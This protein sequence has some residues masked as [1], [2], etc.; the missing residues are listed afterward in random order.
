M[1]ISCEDSSHYNEKQFSNLQLVQVDE[2]VVFKVKRVLTPVTVWKV[3]WLNLVPLCVNIVAPRK[4]EVMPLDRRSLSSELKCI[5]SGS[6][7]H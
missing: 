7:C 3:I 5:L 2:C 1:E 4:E 6:P